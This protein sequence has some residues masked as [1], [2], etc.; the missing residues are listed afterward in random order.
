MSNSSAGRET[1]STRIGFILAA[2]GSAVGLGNIWRFPFQVGQEGG[3]AFIVMYLAF[4]VLIGFPAMM[5]EFVVGRQTGLNAVGGIREFAG[6]AW[7]YLGGLFVFIG[8][9]ILS[10]YSVVGGWVLRYIL[11]SATGGYIAQGPGEYFVQISSGLDAL[12]AHAVFMLLVVIIVALGV[13]QGIELGVKIMVPAIIAIFA[14]LAVYAF[15]LP[16]AGEAYSY[17]LSPDLDYLLANWQSIVPAAA[18]QGFFTLSLGMGVM[19]TYASYLSEDENLGI[20]G[21][22]IV[23]FNTGISILTGLI[24]FPILFSAG[25]DP[26][27]SGAG[28][29]FL[30]VAEA[31]GNL[32]FG[33]II[34][35]LFFT[36]V[37]IAALSSAIS[38]IEV[39][40]SYAIDE[41]GIAR[42]RATILIGS[43]IFLL[44]AP[45]TIDTVMVDLYDIFA[46]QILLVLGGILLVTLVSWLHPEEAIDELSKGI[47]SFSGI[48][49]V[50][51]WTVRIPVLV[52]LIVSLYLG[53]DTF[54]DFLT[55]DAFTDFL[56]SL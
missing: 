54:V 23:I 36:T 27:T 46:A 4:V 1:W 17:Y 7:K 56:A 41:F 53:I 12:A 6:G 18:G 38:L 5:V 42:E 15:T 22:T 2:V 11:G 8:F 13:K 29:I 9:V 39:V 14:L 10:Y 32:Q 51:L 30:S 20:D 34:G 31:L 40:V 24:V 3:A 21:G 37:A 35:V 19:I 16:G 43:A 25:V 55:G 45:V 50:W 26:E 48:D 33:R 47:K 28:A 49:Q 44:G 52:V